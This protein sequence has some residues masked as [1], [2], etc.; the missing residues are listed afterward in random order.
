MKIYKEIEIDLEKERERI[1]S[2]RYTPKQKTKLLRLV[3]QIEQG[4]FRE[5]VVDT[6]KWKRSE[7][8]Y[9]APEIWDILFCVSLGE[10]FTIGEKGKR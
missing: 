10:Q 3:D 2:V 7:R 8:E 6:S 1:H 9:I 5:T 4:L